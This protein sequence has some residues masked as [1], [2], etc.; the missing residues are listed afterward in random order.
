MKFLSAAS[1]PPP[2]VSRFTQKDLPL[3]TAL[4][5]F[6]SSDEIQSTSLLVPFLNV[7]TLFAF[8]HKFV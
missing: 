7:P 8:Q 2:I 1:S 5:F 4:E 6:N 3:E